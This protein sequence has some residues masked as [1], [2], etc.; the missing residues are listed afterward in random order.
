MGLLP[1]ARSRA[2]R[3]PARSQRTSACRA[4]WPG[5]PTAST[6]PPGPDQRGGVQPSGVRPPR[7][8]AGRP[9]ASGQPGVEQDHG[10]VPAARRPARRRGWPR[11]SSG[12]SATVARTRSPLEVR[13]VVAGKAR[14]SSSA[15]RASPRTGA[16]RPRW[17]HSG[18][19][20]PSWTAPH[21]RHAGGVGRRRSIASGPVHARAAGGRAA[22][23]A[24]EA[25]DVAEPRRLHQHRAAP[26]APARISLVDLGGNPRRPG[27]AGRGRS[28]AS[29]APATLTE[30][31]SRTQVAGRRD[32]AGPAGA[33]EVLSP[34]RCARSR[35]PA[36]P[37]PPARR[38]A[39]ASRGC[40][41]R[42]HA[43]RRAGR[44]RRPRSPPGRG[45]GRGRSSR[46]GC[47]RRSGGRRG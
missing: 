37:C 17:P 36:R 4:G 3:S 32:L 11:R 25:G 6:S 44:R 2:R 8:R 22:A 47:R 38:A 15:V 14:P 10:G 40:G 19:A 1:L 35:R 12:R 42:A 28:S 41:G 27:V 21:Q 18:Q 13:I 34:R 39:A 26:R 24:G 30:T 46:R 7:R 23:L 9:R 5:S 29:L 45:R 20:Q 31:R 43:A 16:R 33:E